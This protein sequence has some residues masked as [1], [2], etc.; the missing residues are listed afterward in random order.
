MLRQKQSDPSKYNINNFWK[1]LDRLKH[2]IP[3]HY[4]VLKLYLKGCG[5][6]LV[7]QGKGPHLASLYIQQ[8]DEMWGKG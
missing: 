6:R 4:R 5:G 7:L 2:L 3:S 1:L 8:C